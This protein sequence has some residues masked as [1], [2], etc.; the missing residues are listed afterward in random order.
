[1]TV[2]AINITQRLLLLYPFV[3][4]C[5]Y[6]AFEE[7]LFAGHGR[8]WRRGGGF[9]GRGGLGRG[10]GGGRGFRDLGGLSGTAGGRA[11]V[12]EGQVLGWPASLVELWRGLNGAKF[13][14]EWLW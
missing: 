9:R 4:S 14:I 2:T 13:K 5:A 3:S 8:W 10:E 1:M 11:E 12:R 7:A 6:H